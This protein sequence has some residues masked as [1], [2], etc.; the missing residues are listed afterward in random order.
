M[1]F[2]HLFFETSINSVVSFPYS[3]LFEVHILN[4][5]QHYSISAAKS[6]Q[7][8][9]KISMKTIFKDYLI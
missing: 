6:N 2:W 7:N 9:I 4:R 3:H 1:I 5:L 8:M